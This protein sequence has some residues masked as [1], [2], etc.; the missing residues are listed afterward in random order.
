MAALHDVTE[1]EK[2]DAIFKLR[3]QYDW[4]SWRDDKLD[5]LEDLCYY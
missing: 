3:S 5:D 2:E 1:K 4:K